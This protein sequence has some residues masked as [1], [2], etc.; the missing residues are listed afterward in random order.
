MGLVRGS[1]SCGRLVNA[2]ARYGLAAAAVSFFTLG[3]ETHA[4]SRGEEEPSPADQPLD[5]RWPNGCHI[6]DVD[7]LLV[8]QRT[9]S[10]RC[11]GEAELAQHVSSQWT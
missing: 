10:C 6:E 4:L 5:W 3:I 11:R 2:S 1:G 7:S 9:T 8:S